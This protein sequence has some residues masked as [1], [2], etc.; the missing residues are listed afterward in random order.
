ML[1]ILYII[2]GEGRKRRGGRGGR[3]EDRVGSDRERRRGGIGR[4]EE[5]E[6]DGIGLREVV[7]KGGKMESIVS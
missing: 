1:Y 6:L 5:R 7:V 4:G 2:C 3:E